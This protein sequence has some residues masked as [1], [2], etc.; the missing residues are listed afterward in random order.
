M[1]WVI[2][3]FKLKIIGPYLTLAL[4]RQTVVST[5]YYGI[6]QLVNY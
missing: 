5:N 3:M 4:H 2:Y 1:Q 6:G